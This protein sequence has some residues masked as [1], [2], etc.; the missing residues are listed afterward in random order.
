M[1]DSDLREFTGIMDDLAEMLGG[2]MSP[3]KYELY[4]AALS[5]LDI[6]D[7][8]KAANHIANT[9]TFFPKPK[10]FREA[11]QGDI[12]TAVIGAWEKVLKAKSKAGQ[13]Q[14][15][16]FNDPIIH[17]TIKLMGGWASVCQMENYSDEKWQR[18]DFD[19]IYKAIQ[20]TG[21]DH[22]KYLPG[23]A[24]VENCA[25]GIEYFEPALEITAQT[26]KK[27]LPPIERKALP[28]PEKILTKEEIAERIGKLDI[29]IRE[30]L[31]KV[32]PEE[33]T[34]GTAE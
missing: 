2:D 27:A 14:S 18:V 11:I 30:I 28:E 16:R 33:C 34:S 31:E 25:L 17:G 20:G 29:G 19:K 24:E 3:R 12:E 10:D 1:K 23:S 21:K 9:A 15:V 4:F 22:P 26:E 32:L 13:Y 5:D 6:S 8:R 7:L